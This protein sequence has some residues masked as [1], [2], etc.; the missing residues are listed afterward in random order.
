MKTEIKINRVSN[1]NTM[2]LDETIEHKDTINLTGI[3]ST[4]QRKEARLKRKFDNMIDRLAPK[5]FAF[6]LLLGV[7]T[8]II[9]NITPVT[10]NEVVKVEENVVETNNALCENLAFTD[11]VRFKAECDTEKTLDTIQKVKEEIYKRPNIE[12]TQIKWNNRVY[13]V[14]VW[15]DRVKTMEGLGYSKTRILDL[16]AIMNME[17]GSY[18]GKCFNWNDI[19]PMQIN[20][21]H[22]EQYNKSWEYY[23]K[24]DWGGLFLYQ[25]DYA[26]KLLD[27]YDERFCGA[28]IF[29]Q[30]GRT[31]T[32][33]R[34]FECIGKSYNGHPRYK[35]AYVQLGWERR[36][37]IKTIL[38]Y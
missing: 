27:S 11:E 22:K 25:L 16:L 37:V 19:W 4:R 12:S 34:H 17:C 5:A 2:T 29:K 23:N 36:G 8:V 14:Q 24:E 31:Y 18:T 38:N 30:I 3:K 26:N 28:H 15:N 10:A 21:I 33:K 20:K 6:I 7:I 1:L 9:H 13:N 35:Y 32:N